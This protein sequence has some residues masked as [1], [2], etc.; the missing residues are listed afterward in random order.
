MKILLR[1]I[2]FLTLTATTACGGAASESSDSTTSTTQAPVT[3]A[4]VT[5][6]SSTT[7]TSTTA[8]VSDVS[9]VC[10]TPSLGKLPMQLG[11]S[12]EGIGFLKSIVSENWNVL[13]EIFNPPMD[14]TFDAAFEELIKLIQSGA[15]LPETG[16]VDQ[17]TYKE[18]VS[19]MLI[20]E[21]CIG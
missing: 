8:P 2:V 19:P 9:S 17:A 15:G 5:T 11:D 13:W 12:S 6:T 1:P 18:A 3:S 4:S 20:V 21:G 16:I 7:S 10:G 14:N